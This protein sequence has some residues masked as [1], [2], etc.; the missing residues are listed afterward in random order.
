M[1][2]LNPYLQFLCLL[3]TI[4]ISGCETLPGL[5]VSG[6]LNGQTITTTVD[7]EAA[8]YYLEDY[9][10]GN[11]SDSEL[12]RKIDR[13]HRD[14]QFPWY[15]R[16]ALQQLSTEISPDFATLLLA[17]RLLDDPVNRPIQRLFER[18]LTAVK[19]SASHEKDY[20]DY[21]MLFMPGWD[22]R[23]T[24]YLTGSDF[25][26]P[27]QLVGAMG[28]ENRLVMVDQHGSVEKNAA[29]LSRTL[30]DEKHRDKK[31]IITS[32]SSSGPAVAL[33][34]SQKR[35]EIDHVVSWINVGGI[36]RGSP[37]IDHYNRWP[38]RWY[39]RWE[40][41]LQGWSYDNVVSMSVEQSLPR[42]E[43]LQFPPH[44]KVVNYLG[45]PVSGTIS[46]FSAEKYP[47]L[48]ALGPNDGL[49]PIT[50]AIAPNSVSI[51]SLGPDHYVAEDPEI[52]QKTV[53]VVRAII[54]YIEQR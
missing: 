20:D 54:D 43:S 44:V 19:R 17:Q 2:R 26:T 3:I 9:L 24:G 38:W 8:R 22:Y 32:A 10:N 6:E 14:K 12:D 1:P 45:I 42:F 52:D 13:L 15:K 29:M 39:L 34:L 49:T 37:L 33:A 51:I 5:P 7:S 48:K 36:L 4:T 47:I 50:D 18:H 11:R 53:A 46:R 16:E 28:L 31:I 40:L 23:A 21:L 30:S 41:W 25:A 27:R 35:D